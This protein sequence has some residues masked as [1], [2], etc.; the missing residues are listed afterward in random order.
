MNQASLKH[1]TVQIIA[2]FLTA[3]WGGVVEGVSARDAANELYAILDKASALTHT[4][5]VGICR[6]CGR[7]SAKWKTLCSTCRDRKRSRS[8][9]YQEHKI[10]RMRAWRKARK[11][12][13][14]SDPELKRHMRL[15]WRTRTIAS[16]YGIS[17]D[18]ARCL[19]A[20]SVAGIELR[21]IIKEIKEAENAKD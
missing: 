17:K 18:S 11:E 13:A 5:A 16:K 9:S 6:E 21:N 10:K 20:M 2:S 7:K 15:S 12:K 8:T 4:R 19:A 1:E 14:E 3:K